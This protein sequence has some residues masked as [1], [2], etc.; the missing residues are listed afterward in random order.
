[1]DKS[2]TANFDSYSVDS[3]GNAEATKTE[4]LQ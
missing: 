3:A 4:V 1:V 2:G